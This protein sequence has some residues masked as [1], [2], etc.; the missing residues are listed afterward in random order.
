M[1]IDFQ[2][3][4]NCPHITVDESVALGSDRRSLPLRQPIAS[5]AQVRITLNGIVV[6]AS[7]LNS[8]AQ[9]K[10]RRTGPYRIDKGS[11]T[12]MLSNREASVSI[13]LPVGPRVPTEDIIVSVQNSSSSVNA[14]LDEFGV[15]TLTD[16]F[17]TGPSSFVKVEGSAKDTLGFDIQ[18][19]AKGKQ[20]YPPWSLVEQPA[21]E[22][23]GLTV[24]DIAARYPRFEQPLTGTPVIKVSYVTTRESCLRCRRTGV[25]NDLRAT[26]TGSYLFVQNDDLLR[27]SALKILLTE[28]GS[29]P[30]HPQYGSLLTTRIG[31]KNI[32]SVIEGQLSL[33]SR[34][35]MNRLQTIQRQQGR[36]Q[37][38]SPK[39]TL[40][41]VTGVNVW[42]PDGQLTAYGVQIIVLNA[43]NEPVELTTVFTTP[44]TVALLNQRGQ[45][46]GAF[47]SVAGRTTVLR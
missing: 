25:E 29:N 31:Q 9:I 11:E 18:N 7:G 19:R 17:E 6:P 10:A 38:L 35:A 30:F 12:L 44:G 46:L 4:H 13:K 33:D 24:R 40:A 39:E 1:S 42:Q 37:R 3:G 21:K 43:S 8:P 15:L 36:F 20:V 41:S 27:Q 5:S 23:L 26:P 47:G 2:L 22:L 45:S 34:Q 16:R 14:E 28:K 32:P